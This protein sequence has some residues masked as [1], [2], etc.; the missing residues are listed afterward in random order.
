MPTAQLE[1]VSSVKSIGAVSGLRTSWFAQGGLCKFGAFTFARVILLFCTSPATI[2]LLALGPVCPCGCRLRVRGLL[3]A[4][5][6]GP[7]QWLEGCSDWSPC[8][9]SLGWALDCL[10]A[11]QSGVNGWMDDEGQNQCH[12]GQSFSHSPWGTVAGGQHIHKLA[13]LT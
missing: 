2:K 10:W 11:G 7:A 9:S 4:G 5:L 3:F 13:H 8:Q 1:T 6:V 12:S